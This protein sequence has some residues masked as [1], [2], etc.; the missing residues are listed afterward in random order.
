M[1]TTHTFFLFVFITVLVLCLKMVLLSPKLELPPYSN[2]LSC[3]GVTSD[4]NVIYTG[5]VKL[6]ES[7]LPSDEAQRDQL[8]REAIFYQNLYAFTNLASQNINPNLKFASFG[9]DFPKIEIKEIRK[10]SYGQNLEIDIK[11]E[12]TGFPSLVETYLKSLFTKDRIESSDAALNVTYTFEGRLLL[13]LNSSAP[14]KLNRLRIIY[15]IDPYMTFFQVSKANRK[16]IYNP[17]KE[18]SSVTNPCINIDAL[19][20]DGYNPLGLWNFWRPNL[21]GRSKDNEIFDCRAFYKDNENILFAEAIFTTR[22]PLETKFYDFA[23]LNNLKRPL[24]MAILLGGTDNEGFPKLRPDEIKKYINLYLSGLT[25]KEAD[26]NLPEGY[27][28]HFS[29]MLILLWKLQSHL[30]NFEVS[31]NADDVSLLVRLKGKF[32]LSKKDIDLKIFLSPN[33]PNLPGSEKFA[34]FFAR[35]FLNQDILLYEGHS[36][37]GSIFD[38]GIQLLKE[39]TYSFQDQDLSYQILGIF[40]CSSTF[41]YRP[42]SFPRVDNA[43]FKRDIVRVAGPYS[44]ITG[45]SLLGMISSL[46]QYFYNETYVPFGLWA[47]TFKVDNFFVLSNH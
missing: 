15:P 30:I 42:D 18:A 31:I 38:K 2:Y 34:D 43:K 33:D 36:I 19:E 14:K 20:R 47:K 40:S 44:E 8:L 12:I 1:K 46:D 29:K 24:R 21:E 3:D 4:V 7:F 16:L 9:S 41:H 28:L 26:K 45:N 13:C 6:L 39:K 10:T 35:S 25:L 5:Q 17:F 11:P 27:D 32:K 22:P 37:T 23:H